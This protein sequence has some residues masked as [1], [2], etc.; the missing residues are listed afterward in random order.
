MLDNSPKNQLTQKPTHSNNLQ[1]HPSPF[2]NSPKSFGQLTQCLV[3]SPN[4]VFILNVFIN[5]DKM[6]SNFFFWID[7][8]Y[9][10]R[11]F[12]I[13]HVKYRPNIDQ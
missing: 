13:W 7:L 5:N 3:N 10:I 1:T 12:D 11:K 9:E 4:F 6:L 2:D 8:D